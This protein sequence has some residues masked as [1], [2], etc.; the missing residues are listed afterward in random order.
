[1]AAF[2]IDK[3]FC[4]NKAVMLLSTWKKI[5]LS[6]II[7]FS[8]AYVVYALYLVIA[9]KGIYIVNVLLLISAILNGILSIIVFFIDDEDAQKSAKK[10][11]KKFK[12]S[13]KLGI[14]VLKLVIL[15][16]SF[17]IFA[18]DK[19]A[20]SLALACVMLS[21]T[22]IGIIFDILKAYIA[23]TAKQAAHSVGKGIEHV[24]DALRLSDDWNQVSLTD[25]KKYRF[26]AKESV[27]W[28]T[29]YMLR[30]RGVKDGSLVKYGGRLVFFATKDDVSYV[31]DTRGHEEEFAT[32]S[33]TLTDYKYVALDQEQKD[34]P[35]DPE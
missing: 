20:T 35:T 22:I 18:D 1:M 4:Y 5:N 9:D 8:I 32:A 6:R 23:K 30:K 27:E 24:K 16:G 12:R 2:D 14:Q 34:S 21:I 17:V 11:F 19:S 28:W 13:V 3:A 33:K 15:I 10:A 31:T 29:R 7:I 26:K 25:G